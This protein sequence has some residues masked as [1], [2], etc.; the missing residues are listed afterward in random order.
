MPYDRTNWSDLA[1]ERPRTYDV[2]ENE[3]G[4]VT[5]V[6]AFGE[7]TQEGTM[8]SATRLNNMEDGIEDAVTG[9]EALE[10]WK[11]G[12]DTDSNVQRAEELLDAVEEAEAAIEAAIESIPTDYQTTVNRVTALEGLV[13]IATAAETLTYLGITS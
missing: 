11:Q 13:V 12:M 4:S 2:I 3:D 1:V 8:V 6:P 9:L 10:T 7:T 5:L